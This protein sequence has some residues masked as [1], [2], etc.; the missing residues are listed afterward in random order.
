MCNEF[1]NV[2]CENHRLFYKNLWNKFKDYADT[3]FCKE[4]NID[5]KKYQR[6]WEMYLCNVLLE[7][8]CDLAHGKELTPSVPNNEGPDFIA[9]D[10][11]YIEC[12]CPKKGESNDKVNAPCVFDMND[13]KFVQISGDKEHFEYMKKHGI[14]NIN[15]N[16][17]FD[18]IRKILLRIVGSIKEKYKKYELWSH[19]KWFC[20]EFPYII[21]INTFELGYI[22]HPD[23]PYVVKAVLGADE[24]FINLGSQNSFWTFRKEIQKSSGAKIDV[25][26]FCN[27]EYNEI[28]GILFSNEDCYNYANNIGKDCFLI[29]NPYAKNKIPDEFSV[30]F[31]EFIISISEDSTWTVKKVER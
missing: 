7:K 30:K 28:S 9:K 8:G 13:I 16:T 10:N 24:Q 29:Q 23:M 19:K 11:I 3:N 4:F 17:D 5:E 21:A 22:Q 15:Y 18:V 31:N 27:D 1:N 12:I 26:L 25:D 20:N 6:I 2:I 14:Y